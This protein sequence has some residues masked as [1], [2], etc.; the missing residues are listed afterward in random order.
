M[1]VQCRSP[2]LR[3]AM[4]RAQSSRSFIPD[5]PFRFVGGHT[6][7]DLVNTVTWAARGP[8]RDRLSD[9]ARVLEWAA[10]AGVIDPGMERELRAAA[11]QRPDAAE[12]AYRAA[13]WLRDV[14]QRLLTALGHG[15]IDAPDGTRA[16]ADFNALLP[17]AVSALRIA[18]DPRRARAGAPG[19]GAPGAGAPGAGAP[20]A[21]APGETSGGVAL[22][23]RW[24][25][26]ASRPEAVLWPVVWATAQLL[27][28]PDA[29]QLRVCGGPGCGWVY[30]D[31]SRNGLRRWCEMQTCGTHEKSR[32]RAARQRQGH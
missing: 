5:E 29:A 24:E 31:R 4:R 32:R 3:S 10:A 20:G 11:A 14:L 12:Q 18:R 22:T 27:T 16:L 23:W 25:R 28:S 8:D 17:D 6:A 30:V 1:L 7:A 19:A 9:Y 26:A 2:A 13:R 21:G 15:G